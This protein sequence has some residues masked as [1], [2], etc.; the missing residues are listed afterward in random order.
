MPDQP[1]DRLDDRVDP[2]WPLVQGWVADAV[3]SVEVLPPPTEAERR[4]TLTATGVTTRSPMGAVAYETGG[5]LV[6][7]GWV[8]VLGGG[9]PRL[10]RTLPAWNVGRSAGF[11]L[12][13]DDVL[14]GFF[15]LNGGGIDGP[16]NHIYYHAP[17]TLRWI[18]MTGMGYTA[19]LQWL[20]DG[21]LSLFYRALRWPSW[22][23]DVSA[24]GGDQVL[25]CAPPLWTVEGK[26]LFNVNRRVIPIAE[27]YAL[28]VID[29]PAQF[30]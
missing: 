13:A 1:F 16:P 30:G 5:L 23:A 17:D 6:D 24:V 3:N 18:A 29:L 25:S 21:D 10:P 22:R 20:F 14:G 9:H 2:A 26:D 28:N 7:H 19:F 11:Y 15:A 12:V 8:R 4:A 27:A